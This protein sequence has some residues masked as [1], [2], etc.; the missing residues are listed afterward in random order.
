MQKV[1]WYNQLVDEL[2]REQ[3]VTEYAVAKKARLSMFAVHNARTGRHI[4]NT[5]TLEKVLDALGH[6]LEASTGQRM[7]LEPH[8]PRRETTPN[9]DPVGGSSS[10]SNADD[11]SRRTAKIFNTPDSDS[12]CYGCGANGTMKFLAGHWQCVKCGYVEPCCG[13]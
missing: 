2:M 5:E 4:V 1:R 13:D 3:G 6:K 12:Y 9:P 10:L 8:E 11:N 7:D